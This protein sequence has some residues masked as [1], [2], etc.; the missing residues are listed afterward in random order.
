MI[1][2]AVGAWF[3]GWIDSLI[4]RITEVNMILPAFPILLIVYNFYS[5]SFWALLGVAILL[6]VFGSAIK[7][8]RSAFLQVR[9]SPYIEAA[10]SYGASPLRIIFRYLIPRIAPVLVPQLA[11]LVPAFV[12]LEVTLAYL[13][14]SDPLLPTL[15]KVL[16]EGIENGGLSGAYHWVLEPTVIL[17]LIGFAFLMLGFALER[18]LNPRLRNT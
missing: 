12:F 17:L 5:S 4:Q 15:G 14:M 2:A 13:K 3:G 8:Y 1:I 9:E 18:I 7:S 10:Q 16:Q 6:N 11:I